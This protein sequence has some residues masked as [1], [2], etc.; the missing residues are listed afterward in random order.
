MAAAT[1][2]FPTPRP[3]AAARR[4]LCREMESMPCPL[5]RHGIRKETTNLRSPRCKGA[6]AN[7]EAAA[8]AVAPPRQA[9][10]VMSLPSGGRGGALRAAAHCARPVPPPL[11]DTAGGPRSRSCAAGGG[12]PC[13]HPRR[14]L[15][16]P[17]LA[18]PIPGVLLPGWLDTVAVGCAAL[19]GRWGL[20]THPR[21]GLPCANP[22]AAIPGSCPAPG[23]WPAP[24][25][26]EVGCRAL[27]SGVSSY[28]GVRGLQRPARYP[29]RVAARGCRLCPSPLTGSWLPPRF[30]VVER[31]E[32]SQTR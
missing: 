6:P 4:G 32:E 14:R 17:S 2:S 22:A 1:A 13:T 12:R 30:M 20:N 16:A 5:P 24:I 19:H 8:R 31:E 25:P 11:P 7:G 21:A 29:Q 18:A 3:K 9:R 28:P 23:G 15:L 26:L 27:I 10:G